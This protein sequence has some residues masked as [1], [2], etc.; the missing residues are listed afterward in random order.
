LRMLFVQLRIAGS[1]TRPPYTEFSMRPC[2]KAQGTQVTTARAEHDLRAR[3]SVSA[4]RPPPTP[5]VV[6]RTSRTLTARAQVRGGELVR[7]RIRSPCG[8]Y[9][10]RSCARGGECGGAVCAVCVTMGLGGAR[11]CTTACSHASRK[12]SCARTGEPCETVSEPHPRRCERGCLPRPGL[13]GGGEVCGVCLAQYTH[14]G[15]SRLT[16]P[17]GDLRRLLQQHGGEGGVALCAWPQ[18]EARVGLQSREL[19][20]EHRQPP[21]DRCRFCGQRGV[22]VCGGA[23]HSL[24]TRTLRHSQSPSPPRAAAA[25]APP[26]AARRPWPC[27][28][29][30]RAPRRSRRSPEA[31]ARGPR[32]WS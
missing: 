14:T 16:A 2:T 9:V 12:S 24:T 6:E 1:A 25:A 27:P 13:A 30:G 5:P 31:R 28:C 8:T 18:A 32:P 19:L 4:V 23:D 29:S 7:L 21:H 11:T 22:L 20:L 10:R 3:V 26:P 17:G 15:G